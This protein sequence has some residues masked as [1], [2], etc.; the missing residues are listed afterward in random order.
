M[1]SGEIC[2][3]YQVDGIAQ[4]AQLLAKPSAKIVQE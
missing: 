2:G 4:A 3:H 1:H